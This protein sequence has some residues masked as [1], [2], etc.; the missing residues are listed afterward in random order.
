MSSASPAPRGGGAFAAIFVVLWSTGFIAAKFGLPYAT[1]FAFLLAR[2]CAVALV[3]A[4]IALATAAPWPSPRKAAHTM[5]VGALIQG[6]Y[7]GGVFYAIAHGVSAGTSAMLVGLQPVVTVVLA[8]GWL[9]ERVAA[10]QWLGLAIGLAG[11]ALVVHHRIG[12]D[13]VTSVVAL[14]IALLAISIGTLYQKRYCAD[15]DLRTGA[16]VQF[17]TSAAL[18]V[19]L[20]LVAEPAHI[21][22][23][24]SFVFALG[25]SVVVLSTGANLLLFWLLR[26]GRAADVATLFFLVPA[27]TAVMA[28]ALFGETLT[29]QAIAGMVLIAVGVA[30]GRARRE[31]V[32]AR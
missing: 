4:A 21:E 14:L 24:G 19:P 26:H 29:L 17:T 13:S 12:A 20:A 2:F 31:P 7:L 23:T 16:V 9:G 3:M 30:L 1:P 11:V 15:V 5:L 8:M 22:W 28:W 32:P 27:V 10:R 18:M 6:G 25:W